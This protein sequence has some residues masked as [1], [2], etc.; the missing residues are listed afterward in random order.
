MTNVNHNGEHKVTSLRELPQAI[1]PPRDLWAGI[2]AR[3]TAEREAAGDGADPGAGTRDGTGAG[4]RANT[5]ADV[6]RWRNTSARNLPRLRWLAAAAMIAALAVGVWIGRSVLPGGSVTNPQGSPTT[7][8][9]IPENGGAAA[10]Q[11]AYLSDPTYRQQRA[12]L[13]KSLEKQLASLPPDARAKVVSSLAT[14]HKSM[15]DLEAAL[16]KD[17]SNALLQELLVNTYQDEM[18]VLT[19][20]HEAGDAGKG[21]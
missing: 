19:T 21:I 17:P 10:L 20:V 15:Q 12:A 5:D 3:I 7:A 18:R 6:V 14:I 16:G 11:A 8:R 2:E 1:E 13:V 9:Q 4:S